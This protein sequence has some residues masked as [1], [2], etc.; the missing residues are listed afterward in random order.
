MCNSAVVTEV[1]IGGRD[2]HSM[3]FW[4]LKAEGNN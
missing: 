1:K 2:M 4:H 3:K